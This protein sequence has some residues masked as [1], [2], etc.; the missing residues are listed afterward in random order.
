MPE[1]QDPLTQ[2]VT[3]IPAGL[4]RRVKIH[5]V[6]IESTLTQFVITAIEERLGR[7]EGR[8]FAR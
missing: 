3:R 2:L 4:R 7:E 6:K 8:R 5:C 1:H